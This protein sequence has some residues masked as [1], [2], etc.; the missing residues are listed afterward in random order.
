MS[1]KMLAGPAT[2]ED[3]KASTNV[4]FWIYVGVGVTA[5][6]RV[7]VVR[8]GAVVHAVT[9]DVRERRSAR[10]SR[11]SGTFARRRVTLAAD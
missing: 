11:A 4:D 7:H 3:H 8:I 9:V 6:S 5:D 10:G 2:G 1:L